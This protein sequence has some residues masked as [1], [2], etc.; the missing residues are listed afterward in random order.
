M[1]ARKSITRS[2]EQCGK[3]FRIFPCWAKRGGRF[4][5]QKCAGAAAENKVGR[6]CQ[7]CGKDFLAHPSNIRRGFAKYCSTA[8]KYAAIT[9]SPHDRFWEKVDKNGPA[10]PHRPE[11]GPC[12]LWTG[13][14]KKNGYGGFTE[15]DS[16]GRK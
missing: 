12:W 7:F 14:V 9:R 3:S 2:C 16:I 15:R 11:I 8:C 6:I 10:P 5:S 13:W 1:P 4:C